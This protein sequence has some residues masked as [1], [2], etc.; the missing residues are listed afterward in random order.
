M[1]RS[2]RARARERGRQRDRLH[3]RRPERPLVPTAPSPNRT[4]VFHR[5]TA[6]KHPASPRAR[7]LRFAAIAAAAAIL[8]AAATALHLATERPRWFDESEPRHESEDPAAIAVATENRITTALTARRP[9][10]ATWSLLLTERE[11]NAWLDERL[12]L[13]VERQQPGALPA[14]ARR[15]AVNFTPQSL[16]IAV[17]HA[18]SPGDTRR[19]RRVLSLRLSPQHDQHQSHAR[20]VP[21]AIAVNRLPIPAIA[22][23]IAKPL[24]PTELRDAAPQ[25][26]NIFNTNRQNQSPIDLD[27]DGHRTARL[28]AVDLTDHAARFTFQTRSRQRSGQQRAGNTPDTTPSP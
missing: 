6:T 2:K 18:A 25:L 22:A 16:R 9:D 7:A 28:I 24:L 3:Q 1:S 21:R 11:A 14:S 10:G 27:I 20:F 8:A 17:D 19:E 26:A 13:W 15:V 5:E 12:R 23:A 4:R